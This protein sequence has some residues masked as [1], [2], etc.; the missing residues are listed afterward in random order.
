MAK[1]TETKRQTMVNNRKLLN[2]TNPT[3]NGGELFSPV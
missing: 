2:N 3:E 1:K